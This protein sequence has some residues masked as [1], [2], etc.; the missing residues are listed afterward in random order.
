MTVLPFDKTGQIKHG[1]ADVGDPIELSVWPAELNST[2][3]TGEAYDF[4]GE[5]QEEAAEDLVGKPNRRIVV[6]GETFVVVAAFFHGYLP[7]VELRLRRM[8]AG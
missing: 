8:E 3:A 6:D 7:H 5:A 1:G 2:T 4:T